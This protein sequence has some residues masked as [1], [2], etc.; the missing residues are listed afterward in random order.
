MGLSAW[1]TARL[2]FDGSV[3]RA[4]APIAIRRLSSAQSELSYSTLR[5]L[6]YKLQS[7]PSLTQ[8][9]VDEGEVAQAFNSSM[10]RTNAI[11]DSQKFYRAVGVL[12]P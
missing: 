8:P 9:F 2:Y 1:D 7:T 10:V 4:P 12:A 11:T 5:G 6:F 3:A